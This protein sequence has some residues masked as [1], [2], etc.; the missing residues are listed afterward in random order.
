MLEYKL[1]YKNQLY[2]YKE[3]ETL[4]RWKLK[5]IQVYC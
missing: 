4:R 2:F 5:Y 3:H 1:M